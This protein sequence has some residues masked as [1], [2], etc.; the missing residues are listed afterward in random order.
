MVMAKPLENSSTLNL[1]VFTFSHNLGYMYYEELS[2]K[3]E[4]EPVLKIA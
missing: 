3:Y 4:G 2:K 1:Y